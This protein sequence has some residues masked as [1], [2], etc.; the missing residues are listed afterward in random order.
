[1]RSFVSTQWK[2]LETVKTHVLKLYNII[3]YK[4]ALKYSKTLHNLQQSTIISASTASQEKVFKS[5][6]SEEDNQPVVEIKNPS[7]ISNEQSIP[8]WKNQLTRQST[9]LPET[10][11]I[12]FSNFQ[13]KEETQSSV[14]HLSQYLLHH[15]NEKHTF[16]KVY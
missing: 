15:P 11:Q 7:K 4:S 2:S 14:E 5:H 16:I 3:S 9:K 13:N 6:A 10:H 8:K 12:I 1:M